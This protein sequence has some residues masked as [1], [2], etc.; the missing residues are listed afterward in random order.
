SIKSQKTSPILPT[1]SAPAS[2]ITTK[3][4]L[5]RAIASRT[6]A[7]SPTCLAVYAVSAIARTNES[8]VVIFA[9][10]SGKIGRSL[11]R[12]GSCSTRPVTVFAEAFFFFF[13]VFFAFAI[14]LLNV[15]TNCTLQ[16]HFL[17]QNEPSLGKFLCASYFLFF[18]LVKELSAL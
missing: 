1:V 12:R 11:S 3:Q 2:V 15:R 17:R 8:I 13:S 7:P 16:P 14:S 4:S 6:S 5:S 10:S 18:R 9:R